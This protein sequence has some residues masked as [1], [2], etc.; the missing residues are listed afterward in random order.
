[1][2]SSPA[3]CCSI[4]ACSRAGAVVD[5][6]PFAYRALSRAIHN[7]PY[8]SGVTSRMGLFS[9]RTRVPSIVIQYARTFI[10]CV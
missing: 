10:V 1:M 4:P 9:P 6:P 8:G 2:G 3:V 7:R 5:R